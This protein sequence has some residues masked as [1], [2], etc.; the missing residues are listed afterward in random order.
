MAKNPILT[1]EAILRLVNESTTKTSLP[2]REVRDI[3]I[4]TDELSTHQ[5]VFC[6]C[7]CDACVVTDGSKYWLNWAGCEIHEYDGNGELIDQT[8]GS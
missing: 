1:D 6:E 3:E 8:I 5:Y 2:R 4:H 7:G